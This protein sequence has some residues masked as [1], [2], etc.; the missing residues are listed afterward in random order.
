MQFDESQSH[1]VNTDGLLA[2]DR[3]SP[4]AGGVRILSFNVLCFGKGHTVHARKAHCQP[5][6]RPDRAQ[7]LL[8]AVECLLLHSYAPLVPPGQFQAEVPN[9]PDFVFETPGT[10]SPGLG[11]RCIWVKILYQD[12]AG[13]LWAND[14]LSLSLFPHL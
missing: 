10:S 2:V 6:C 9:Q 8:N 1:L 7:Y 11:A 14:L 13:R 5:F 12:W 3:G 4:Q